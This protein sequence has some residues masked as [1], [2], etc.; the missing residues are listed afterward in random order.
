MAR[1]KHDPIQEQLAQARRAQILDAA[2]QVFAEKGFHRATI[3]DVAKAAGIAD[4]TIY[5]YFENKTALLLGLLNRIN[6]TEL[7]GQHFE[8]VGRGDVRAFVR[9]YIRQRFE[10]FAQTGFEVFQV[11]LSEILV[12]SEL[13]ELYYQQV[14]APTFDLAE[15]YFQQWADAGVIRL[16]DTR[17]SLRA[18][19]GMTLGLIMLRIM[20]DAELEM[21][22]DAVPDLVADIMLQAIEITER[23]RS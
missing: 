22:W 20:G 8:Q 17:L 4:G 2:T 11:L 10:V 9:S 21:R 5:N 13:R 1:K 12:D 19:A 3:R 14:I 16:R 7:R 6:E 15:R 23:D 18:I